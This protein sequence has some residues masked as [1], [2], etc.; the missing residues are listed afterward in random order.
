MQDTQTT[1]ARRP[2][3]LIG[4]TLLGMRISWSPDLQ[5]TQAGRQERKQELSEKMPTQQR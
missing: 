1:E 2:P 3:K 4:D 5:A